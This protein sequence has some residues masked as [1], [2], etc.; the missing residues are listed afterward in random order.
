MLINRVELLNFIKILGID[1][2]EIVFYNNYNVIV[3][4]FRIRSF[5][6]EKFKQ[7]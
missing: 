6:G 7:S 5:C 2:A 1:N 4:K 3:E